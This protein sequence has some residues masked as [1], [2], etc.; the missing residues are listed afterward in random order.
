MTE[1]KNTQTDDTQADAQV[2]GA[3]EYVVDETPLATSQE[4]N[5]ERVQA[6]TEDERQGLYG[7][8]TQRQATAED[9]QAANPANL[10]KQATKSA[11]SDE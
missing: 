7:Q 8:D 3:E 5:L 6:Q 1:S 11:D 4:A 10:G 9:R 2:V